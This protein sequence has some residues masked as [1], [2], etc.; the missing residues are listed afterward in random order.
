MDLLH[1]QKGSSINLG[2]D[3]IRVVSSP[4]HS[5]KFKNVRRIADPDVDDHDVVADEEDRF[6]HHAHVPRVHSIGAEVVFGAVAAVEEVGEGEGRV[7]GAEDLGGGEVECEVE[8]G[9]ERERE[10]VPSK[11]SRNTKGN[12]AIRING[13][14]S[15]RNSTKNEK[16]AVVDQKE[17]QPSARRPENFYTERSTFSAVKNVTRGVYGSNESISG[18]PSA[19]NESFS[20]CSGA[21]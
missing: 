19:L 15:V 7:S 20:M 4:K 10:G 18:M 1:H 9:E 2:A 16:G 21:R 3:A 13:I 12:E 8:R 5:F 14:R 6:F 17:Q 11:F